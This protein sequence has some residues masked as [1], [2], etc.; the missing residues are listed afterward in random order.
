MIADRTAESGVEWSDEVCRTVATQVDPVTWTYHHR[1]DV[2][3]EIAL[4][5]TTNTTKVCESDSDVEWS[6]V[7]SRVRLDGYSIY[8]YV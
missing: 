8:L 1:G 6:G 7:L 2:D 5:L 3:I 4:R